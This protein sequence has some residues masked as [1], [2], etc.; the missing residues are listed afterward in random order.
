M[1]GEK[2]SVELRMAVLDV[3][4]APNFRVGG[5]GGDVVSVGVGGTTFGEL[6]SPSAY[7]DIST[8][9]DPGGRIIDLMIRFNF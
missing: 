1:I 9:N 5:W 3:L 6:A 2:R 8:T 4:N 7:Q